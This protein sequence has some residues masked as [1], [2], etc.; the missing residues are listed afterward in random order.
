VRDTLL[1]QRIKAS[2]MSHSLSLHKEFYNE[3]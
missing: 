2:D 3:S 1:N